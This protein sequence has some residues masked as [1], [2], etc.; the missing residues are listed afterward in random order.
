MKTAAIGAMAA[1]FIGT[2]VALA[3]P[4]HIVIERVEFLQPFTTSGY[5]FVTSVNGRGDFCGYAFGALTQEFEY[6]GTQLVPGGFSMIPR[7]INDAR[8]VV[9]D[10]SVTFPPSGFTRSGFSVQNIGNRTFKGV[11]SKGWIVGGKDILFD[12]RRTGIRR[13]EFGETVLPGTERSIW[14]HIDDEGTVYGSEF[15][16]NNERITLKTRS[17][18]L[19]DLGTFGGSSAHLMHVNS[20]GD[21]AGYTAGSGDQPPPQTALAVIAGQVHHIPTQNGNDAAAL[22]VTLDGQIIGADRPVCSSRCHGKVWVMKNGV[23]F[24][25]ATEIAAAMHI[26]PDFI[27]AFAANENGWIIAEAFN[28]ADDTYQLIRIKIEVI[29]DSDG[30]GLLDSWEA[31]GG[32]I[33]VNQDG[34]I[35][36]CLYDLGAR[37][38]HKDVFVEVDAGTFSLSDEA[39]SRVLFAFGNAPVENP[40]GSTGIH[41]H[42]QKDEAGLSLPNAISIAGRFPEGFEGTKAAHFGTAAERS[43]ANHAAI[44]DAK[45]RA[46]RYCLLYDGITFSGD[47]GYIGIAEIGGN[48]FVVDLLDPIF[49][50]GFRDIDDQASTFMHELGHNLGLRH[51]GAADVMDAGGPRSYQGKPN[52][53]SIMNY[54][55]THPTRWSSR[56]WTLDYCREELRTLQEGSLDESAGIPSTLYRGYSMPYGVGSELNREFRLVRLNGTGTDFNDDAVISNRRFRVSADLNFLPPEAGVA[57]TGT[58]SPGDALRGYNDWANLA[59]RIVADAQ[60][61]DHDITIADGC[62]TSASVAYLNLAFPGPCSADFNE[63]GGVDGADVNAFFVAW[64]SGVDTAD[65][66]E[67][68]GVD[69]ADVGDFFAVWEVGGC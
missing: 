53:P 3:D 44:L 15:S 61:T 29:V 40:D 64:E 55:L 2:G 14:T 32:G 65:L 4:P 50:D 19:R 46:F 25:L 22:A 39:I 51:G 56:F 11:N 23:R 63:D 27:D 13:D 17:G 24:D 26:T 57:G 18:N 58:P 67:D 16:G 35:D 20:R 31:L 69:G 41:L 68:G 21:L 7:G 42:I 1:L 52:Y 8:L 37:P 38:D 34:V 28:P 49:H 9:G 62:P 66:N 33:D 30:D 10:S 36:L 45:A 6:Y 59:Y 43:D 48:D 54:A 12:G 47:S 5:N 60:E